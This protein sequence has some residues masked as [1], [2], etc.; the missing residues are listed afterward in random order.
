MLLGQIFPKSKHIDFLKKKKKIRYNYKLPFRFPRK[1]NLFGFHCFNKK[2]E[3][4]PTS[5]K[6]NRRKTGR[7]AAKQTDTERFP[8][9][10]IETSEMKG[11][12]YLQLV[13]LK[14][15]GSG[16]EDSRYKSVWSES[17]L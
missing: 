14:S 4:R 6:T 17:P 3:V 11:D 15:G 10:K 1:T 8:D 9:P 5:S 13:R 7:Q 12:G 16:S 2:K